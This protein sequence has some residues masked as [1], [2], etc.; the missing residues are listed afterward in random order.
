MGY[1]EVLL[2]G[3]PTPSLLQENRMS[4]VQIPGSPAPLSEVLSSDLFCHGL[5][6]AKNF[7]CWAKLV[8]SLQKKYILLFPSVTVL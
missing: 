5:W 2:F 6:G 7:N 8:F 4:W 1:Q 3:E